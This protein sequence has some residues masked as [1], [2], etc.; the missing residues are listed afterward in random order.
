MGG[1]VTTLCAAFPFR[2]A[3]W[4]ADGYI[5]ASPTAQTLV[6]VPVGGGTPQPVTRNQNGSSTDRWPELL[7]G[8]H[9]AL[10]TSH[11]GNS[12][13]DEAT[14]A[15]VDLAT[16]AFKSVRKGGYGARYLPTGH[17]VF[18]N[19]GVLYGVRFNLAKLETEGDSVAL[20]EGVAGGA[21][22]ARYD[23][24]QT[25]TLIYQPGFPQP[26][27]YAWDFM[28]SSG[29]TQPLLTTPGNYLA[30]R[31]SPDGK[32]LAMM[33]TGADGNH[34]VLYDVAREAIT[35]V[36][37]GGARGWLGGRRMASTLSMEP[38]LFKWYG[39]APTV[40]ASQ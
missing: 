13:F 11:S 12:A 20:V 24:A 39:C 26:S 17:M 30:P 23:I 33:Q 9:H 1:A 7:P 10:F 19:R 16:G 6:R 28:D 22:G 37:S 21:G 27:G 5:L 32:S 14:I 8:G 3:S 34:I 40:L 15:S 31:F 38:R 2:G 18:L 36:D 25:G 29:Q 4:S 35:R